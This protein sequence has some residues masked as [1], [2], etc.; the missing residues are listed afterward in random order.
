MQPPT[1]ISQWRARLGLS[2]RAA[3][4]ALGMRLTAYQSHERGISY[5]TGKPIRTSRMMLLAC[6]AIEAGVKPIAPPS[7]R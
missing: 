2:Q 7:C 6:A 3:A 1:L 5:N 4:A